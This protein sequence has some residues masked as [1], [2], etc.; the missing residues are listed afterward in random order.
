VWFLFVGWWLSALSIVIAYVLCVTVLGLPFAFAIFNRLPAIIT[1]RPRIDTHAVGVRGGVTYISGGT[2]P[3]LSLLVRAIC[4]V[5]VGW[6]LGAI[7][8]S[9]A[10]ALYV[11]LSPLLI[12]IDVG[13]RVEAIMTLLRY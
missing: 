3:Q 4:F 5:L 7:Y 11:L 6:W 13:N 1:L 8:L 12:G 2:V 9:I 10:W